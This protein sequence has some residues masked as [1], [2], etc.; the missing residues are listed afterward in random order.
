MQLKLLTICFSFVL[1]FNSISAEEPL[2]YF[3]G[4]PSNFEKVEPRHSTRFSGTTIVWDGEAIF[5]TPDFRIALFYTHNHLVEVS[6]GIDLL[7]PI[8]KDTT[9][10]FTVLGGENLEDALD[11]LF[12][13]K[14]EPSS[15]GY[16]YLLDSTYFSWMEGLGSMERISTEVKANLGK[17]EI[18]RRDLIEHFI[19]NGKIKLV[20]MELL[21]TYDIVLNHNE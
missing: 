13:I 10:N 18:D 3:H 6:G 2:I 21:P 8:D 16:I 4:S 17:V 15:K 14:G 19:R 11:I 5:A 9:I 7:T 20:W 12:G 1:C